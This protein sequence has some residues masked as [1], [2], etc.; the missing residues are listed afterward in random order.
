[1]RK[2]LVWLALAVA[3]VVLVGIN[4]AMREDPEPDLGAPAS[5]TTSHSAYD[6][7][8]QA[9]VLPDP[10]AVEAAAI[11]TAPEDVVEVVAEGSAVC[12]H[13]FV[14][15]RPRQWRRY[16]WT[17]SDQDRAAVLRIRAGNAREVEGELHVAWR[18]R[19]V[20][21]DDDSELAEQTMI[22]R[23]VP[24][25]SAEEPWFGILERSLGL[26]LTARSGRWRWPAS[27][28]E[29]ER[30]EG[31]A[32]FDPRRAHMR[33]PEGEEES[34]AAM[35]RVTRRHVVRGRETVEVPAGT[36]EAWRVDYEERQSFGSHGET[37]TGSLWVA[38]GVGL[39]KSEA[40][41]SEGVTQTIVLTATGGDE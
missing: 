23:C 30:F 25:E 8:E 11:E 31:T 34:E 27:L 4:L 5:T 15:S 29:D 24:G 13:P 14:P 33:P 28:A 39:V 19:V 10:E 26:R 20:A 1:M 40:E 36:Y 21:D 2:K 6:A 38:E 16:R 12:D 22:T 17:Q 32:T 18:V 41:N 9:V 7:E 37:G 3:V 35:L